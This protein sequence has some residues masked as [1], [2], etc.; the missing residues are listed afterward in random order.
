VLVDLSGRQVGLLTGLQ[1]WRDLFFDV[2]LVLVVVHDGA[3]ALAELLWGQTG[4]WPAHVFCK[5]KSNH[6]HVTI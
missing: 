6:M 4:P 3:G 5:E 1:I 2:S